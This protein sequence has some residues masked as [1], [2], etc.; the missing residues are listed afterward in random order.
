MQ[1]NSKAAA[2]N[3][4][5]KALNLHPNVFSRVHNM[6]SP[7]YRAWSSGFLPDD[8]GQISD[9]HHSDPHYLMVP[10]R[11]KNLRMYL[12]KKPLSS[13]PDIINY[14]NA[15]AEEDL[16]RH[17]INMD[18]ARSDKS[19]TKHERRQSRTAASK[20]EV[21]L[22]VASRKESFAKLV[23]T[24]AKRKALEANDQ[25]DHLQVHNT[26]YSSSPI[27]GVEVRNTTSSKL[28]YILNEVCGNSMELMWTMPT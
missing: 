5:W 19:M 23:E 13:V 25:S 24:Q 9:M 22:A 28:N 21:G 12:V 18:R 14:G 20:M 16:Y 7:I 10:D 17:Q 1:L 27:A 15:I 3:P 4:V 2:H 26:L 6:P 11:L 8:I